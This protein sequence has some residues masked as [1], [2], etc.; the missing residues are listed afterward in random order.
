MV[1]HYYSK[2]LFRLQDCQLGPLGASFFHFLHP[3]TTLMRLTTIWAVLLSLRLSRSGCLNSHPVR[4]NQ[5]IN[6]EYL[7]MK[8][9][10][11]NSNDK[12][13]W[14]QPFLHK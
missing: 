1:N 12:I 5:S 3:A 6:P 13:T 7:S 8:V 14:L 10:D 11:N 4:S 9:P 2:I